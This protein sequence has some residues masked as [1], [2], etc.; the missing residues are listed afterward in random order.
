MWWLFACTPDVRGLYESER[1]AALTVA[2]E[3]PRDWD[4]DLR[5]QI[6][7]PDL[8]AAVATAL[9]VA[10]AEAKPL[11]LELPLGATASL[12]PRLS[13]DRAKLAGSDAC[14]ACLAFD[15]KL[16]GHATWEVMGARGD[17]PFEVEADGVLAVEV[18]EG[19][20]VQARPYRVGAVRVKLGDLEGLRVNPSGEIQE[21]IRA[22]LEKDL[23]PIRIVDLD[24]DALPV[25]DLRLRTGDG[26]VTVE[27]LTDVPG[28]KPAAPAEKL[29]KGVR[30]SVSETALVGLARRAA[31]EQ[32]TVAMEVAA[33][34]RG[35]A[36]EG[37][38]F[39]LSL[40]LWRL[41]GRGW[42]RDYEV[43]GKLAIEDGK[44]KLTPEDVKETGRSQ[45]A[46]LVDPLAALFQ[47]R[48]MEAI[49]DVIRRSL[50]AHR[51]ESLGAVQL[52]AE[53]QRVSGH[54]GTLSVDG[55]LDLTAP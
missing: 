4:A 47:N 37:D 17:F 3:R 27:A 43:V 34:P 25:R 52:K 28:S 49:A 29:A 11:K 19:R 22:E 5:V 36:V 45:G 9:R 13:V 53:A 31:F 55:T 12:K 23:P 35:I 44:L 15:S 40:R 39:T 20:R 42:W 41:V 24:P 48:V 51:K 38:R 33:D 30:V 14:K 50:P 8:E 2:T 54:D 32:G 21:W 46:G 6:G 1:E 7:E 10:V 16:N 26:S 18:A